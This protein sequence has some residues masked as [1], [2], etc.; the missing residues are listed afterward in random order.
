MHTLLEDDCHLT[1]TAVRWEMLAHFLHK[2]VEATIVCGLQELE[3]QKDCALRISLELMEEHQKNR[4]VVVLNFLTQYEELGNDWGYAH[5]VKFK[6]RRDW[7]T[8]QLW[9]CVFRWHF[10]HGDFQV[11]AMRWHTIWAVVARPLCSMVQWTAK[12][13]LIYAHSN[14]SASNFT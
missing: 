4:T 11:V 8:P 12:K 13:C 10:S 2:P 3:M 5:M 9:D 6:S 14:S 7:D 1:I